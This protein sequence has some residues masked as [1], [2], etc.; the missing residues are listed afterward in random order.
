VRA[1]AEN[2]LSDI[3]QNDFLPFGTFMQEDRF[4][5]VLASDLLY[6]SSES[7]CQPLKHNIAII[8]AAWHKSSYNEGGLVDLHITPVGRMRGAFAHANYVEALLDGRIYPSLGEKYRQV[9]EFVFASIVAVFLALKIGKLR[10]ATY[11]TLLCLGII[12][13]SYFFWQN[14]GIFFDFFFPVVL[15]LVHVF[16]DYFHKLHTR[17]TA[18][19]NLRGAIE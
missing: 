15:L 7:L 4:P 19:L 11:I 18:L 12:V 8:G 9:F 3:H 10:R 1:V 13:I 14:L 5:R 2:M 16:L 6:N 17:S